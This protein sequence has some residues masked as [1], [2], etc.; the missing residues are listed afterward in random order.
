LEW[1]YRIS[2]IVYIGDS[3]EKTFNVGRKVEDSHPRVKCR[4]AILQGEKRSMD[5]EAVLFNLR[6]SYQVED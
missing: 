6:T 2:R 1:P 5:E 3:R 4:I